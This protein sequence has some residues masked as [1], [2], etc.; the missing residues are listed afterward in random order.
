MSCSSHT[1]ETVKS[2]L[3]FTNAFN[4][5]C[6]WYE[7]FNL[8]ITMFAVKNEYFEDYKFEHSLFKCLLN[9]LVFDIVVLASVWKQNK[10]SVTLHPSLCIINRVALDVCKYVPLEVDLSACHEIVI[11]HSKDQSKLWLCSCIAKCYAKAFHI[12]KSIY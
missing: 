2:G 9:Y 10:P 11:T 8:T 4:A 5:S 1:A 12:Y 3:S 7:Y 6:L